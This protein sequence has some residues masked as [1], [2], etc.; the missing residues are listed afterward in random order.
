MRALFSQA[1]VSSSSPFPGPPPCLS[2]RGRI[3]NIIVRVY[4]RVCVGKTISRPR[5]ISPTRD[6]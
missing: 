3:I 4:E 1:R 2:Y 6:Q 5:R